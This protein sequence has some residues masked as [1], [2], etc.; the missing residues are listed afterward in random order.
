MTLNIEVI[1]VRPEAE[2]QGTVHEQVVVG[3]LSDGTI[4]GMFDHDLCVAPESQGEQ[5][6]LNVF[7][8]TSSKDLVKL[9]ETRRGV[10]PN[11][12]TPRDYQEHV[13]R[14]SIEYIEEREKGAFIADL[15]VGVGSVRLHLYR[16]HY[17]D[18]VCGDYVV[19]NASR[20][21]IEGVE[22]S[23]Q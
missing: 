18:L 21:D 5:I 4:L 10:D 15:D 16:E 6:E 13:Y 17:P 1:E 12:F 20:T 11:S 14:G 19:V 9:D 23:S 22:D 8:L 2:Y 7:L 3:K